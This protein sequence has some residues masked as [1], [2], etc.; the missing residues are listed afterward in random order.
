MWVMHSLALLLVQHLSTWQASMK[1]R[2][3]DW[4]WA[5]CSA[6]SPPAPRDSLSPPP[7]FQ[8]A[9]PRALRSS[10]TAL[11]NCRHS[12]VMCRITDRSIQFQ[13][14][15]RERPGARQIALCSRPIRPN[16]NR[17]RVGEKMTSAGAYVLGGDLLGDAPPC[18]QHY[19]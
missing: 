3:S 10:D 1:R 19:L 6:P 15:I 14:R 12:H 4:P 9:L 5:R 16:D 8:H 7:F 11:T 17:F 13:S 2:L 18:G